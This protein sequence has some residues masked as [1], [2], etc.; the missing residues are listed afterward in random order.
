MVINGL[1]KVFVGEIV[2]KGKTTNSGLTIRVIITSLARDVQQ[3]WGET[4]ALTPNQLREAYR[5]YKVEK[6]A[7]SDGGKPRIPLR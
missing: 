4:G 3:Q 1:A 2:E 7:V 5:L 6:G